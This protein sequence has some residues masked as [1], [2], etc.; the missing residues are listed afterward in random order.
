MYPKWIRVEFSVLEK[1]NGKISDW[2]KIDI[3]SIKLFFLFILTGKIKFSDIK[4]I[5]VIFFYI[6]LS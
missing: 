4:V 6:Y 1:R 5:L 2:L 3:V